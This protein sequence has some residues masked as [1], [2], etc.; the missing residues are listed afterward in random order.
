MNKTIGRPKGK[1]YP[2]KISVGFSDKIYGQ[3]SAASERL[4]MYVSDVVRECV[5]HDLPRL[6]E[7]KNKADKRAKSL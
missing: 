7:R 4:D 2:H 1:R 3:I 5:A 6:I